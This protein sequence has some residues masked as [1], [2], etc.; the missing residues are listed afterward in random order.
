MR[1]VAKATENDVV[2]LDGKVLRGAC[3]KAAGGSFITMVSAWSTVNGVVLGQVANEEGSNEIA[4]LPELLALLHLKGCL[5]TADAAG[6]QTAIA[7]RIV[8]AGG[9]YLLA[10]RNNQPK[11]HKAVT[12]RF[13]ALRDG[14][15]PAP[16][17]GRYATTSEN[18][19]GRAEVR[20]C[21][22]LPF[23][24]DFPEASRW[25]NL[26]QIVV[27][28]VERTVNGEVSCG[29]R[30]FITSR[31]SM[32]ANQ[33][34]AAVRGHWQIENKLHWTLDVAFREDDCRVRSENAAENF[35]VI[36]HAALNLLRNVKGSKVGIKNRRL[37]AGWDEAF[38]MRV[39]ASGPN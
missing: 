34:L 21:W 27:F 13:E 38:L 29:R 18:R 36:R 32:T 28:E 37:E 6:C 19:G 10:V 4:A 24:D 1:A 25:T 31:K 30:M 8:E 17:R 3:N 14:T 20:R 7:S 5:V 39:L 11:L 22:A 26:A 16:G 15:Q 35:A 23:N 9:D 12:K 33:A 2:A